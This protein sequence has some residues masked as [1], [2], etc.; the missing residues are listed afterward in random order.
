MAKKEKDTRT[1]ELPI[2]PSVLA[3]F[4]LGLEKTGLI[5]INRERLS[6]I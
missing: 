5:R 6:S 2:S 1:E 3:E 4:L